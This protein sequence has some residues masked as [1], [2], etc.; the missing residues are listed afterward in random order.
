MNDNNI[1]V[2]LLVYN[3]EIHL[4]R[5][6]DNLLLLTSNIYVIDSYSTDNTIDI[7]N[8]YG[9]SFVQNKFANQSSQLNFAINNYPF[10][11]N[12][13]LR[14][15]CDE[16]LSDDLIIEMKT[17]SLLDINS[18]VSGFYIKRKVKFFNKTLNYGN[19][20]PIFLLRLWKR[21]KGI[22]DDKLMDEKIVVIDQKTAKLQNIIL[23][24]NLNNL[25]WWTNKHNNYSNREAL[26]ILKSKYIVS[27]YSFK[28]NY[29][30]I[31]YFICL[32]KV[33]Y[34]KMPIFFRSFLLFFYSYF[35]KL[36]ILDGLPGFIWNILQVFWYR[37]LV[38]V[39]VYEFE[40]LH[41]FDKEK[42]KEELYKLDVK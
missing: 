32:L 27:S 38:D 16:L 41:D 29:Y 36:G 17:S 25:T 20:N 23:D 21:G 9:I 39:K 8:E 1:G 13:I 4:K 11:T 6:L 2:I 34:N 31:D 7:L 33:L 19:I 18:G 24:N 22:C 30:S 35:L 40:Y 37:Y 10:E 42:I 14:V 3:E 26:E 15:D 5:C 12:W 28:A